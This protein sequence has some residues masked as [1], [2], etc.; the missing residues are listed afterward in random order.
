MHRESHLDFHILRNLT[1]N[2]P[3]EHGRVGAHPLC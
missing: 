2:N 1:N 3:A